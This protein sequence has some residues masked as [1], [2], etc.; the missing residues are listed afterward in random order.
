MTLTF[1]ITM[2]IVMSVINYLKSIDK[3]FNPFVP[4]APFLHP[5]KTSESFKFSDVFKV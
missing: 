3:K 5:L 2:K 4:G 1:R